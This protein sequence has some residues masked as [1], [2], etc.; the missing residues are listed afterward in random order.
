MINF[1]VFDFDGVFTDGKITYNEK[2]DIIKNYNVKD[3]LGLSRLIN[4]NIII[5]VISGYKYN[6]SQM[7][8]LKH[9]NV[10]YISLES[11][12]KLSVLKKWCSELNIN[13]ENNVAYMGDDINDLEIINIVKIS[14]CPN[15]AL[16][17]VKNNVNFISNK[18]GGNGCVREFSDYILE[19]NII[20]ENHYNSII[21]EIKKEFYYQ[22]N[23][24]NL[25][26]IIELSNIIKETKN[27]I[28]LCGV[29]KSGNIAKHCADLLKS[30]SYPSFYFNI[31]NSTHGDIGTMTDNDIIL[32]FSNSGNTIE[33]IN[34]IPLFKKIGLKIIGICS[35]ETS[36][37]K[38]LCDITIITPFNKEISGEINKIP[39]NSVMS[40]LI[41]CNILISILKTN[42]SIEKYKENHLSGNIGT[43]LITIK[44]VLITDYPKFIFDNNNTIFL[45]NIILL[46]MTKYEIG[47]CFFVNSNE[48][49][50]GILTD[51][52]IRRLLLTNNIKNITIDNI[53]T[54]Y[55]C[56]ENKNEY[57]SNLNNINENNYFPILENNKIIG[58]IST[59]RS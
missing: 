16:T 29:G 56:F 42:V 7:E 57:L 9:L 15:D 58:I 51:G 13:I 46:E 48:K 19:Q 55:K 30:I 47:C 34:I 3:G 28:Y 26:K 8:I 20:K 21:S 17:E 39:T 5:G 53:N 31:L 14:G 37:F 22:I 44:D 49:L 1:V 43:S 24:F 33:L 40:H 54:K 25:D 2:G 23:N 38:K 12:N 11:K 50:I 35:N 6:I 18:N 27:N 52:D 10:T 59:I 41:W 32:L 45:L 4:N 36:N